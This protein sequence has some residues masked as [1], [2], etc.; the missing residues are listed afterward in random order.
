MTDLKAT[1]IHYINPMAS[2][3]T[4]ADKCGKPPDRA[5]I[6]LEK[7]KQIM[8]NKT[9]METLR[10]QCI[11]LRNRDFDE[12]SYAQG[13][14]IETESDFRLIIK[15][16]VQYARLEAGITQKEAALIMQVKTSTYQKWERGE[17]GMMPPFQIAK[18]CEMTGAS[19]FNFLRH[20]VTASEIEAFKKRKLFK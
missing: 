15:A 7:Q 14:K 13:K 20:Y 18:F 2:K 19:I 5:V 4:N 9:V 11:K 6:D 1:T 8:T 12:Q 10:N 17:R 16:R 3:S